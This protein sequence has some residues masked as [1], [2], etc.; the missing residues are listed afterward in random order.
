[1][2]CRANHWVRGTL[3]VMLTAGQR[4]G[5]A[6]EAC[7]ALAA[8]KE[9]E[10]AAAW[11]ADE[12]AEAR[13]SE[14]SFACPASSKNREEAAGAQEQAD[15]EAALR[16]ELAKVAA[17]QKGAVV[18]ACPAACDQALAAKNEE[19]AAGAWRADEAAKAVNFLDAP[20]KNREEAAGAQELADE[21]AALRDKLAEVAAA[22]K[23][24]MVMACP[25]ACESIEWWSETSVRCQTNNG[26][27]G[28]VRV[29]FTAG[30]RVGSVNEACDFEIP[31]PSIT[32]RVNRAG[33]GSAK[34][35]EQASNFGL[36]THTETIRIM[37]TACGSTEWWSQT[38]VQCRTSH[39][40]RGTHRMVMTTGERVGTV[41]E[42]WS[43]E[44]PSLSITTRLNR[45]GTG[46][47]S[48]TVHGTSFGLTT[49]TEAIRI[50]DTAC[51][52]TEWWSETTVR[53]RTWHGVRGTRRMMLTTGERVGTVTEAW[54][55]DTPML[56]ITTRVNQAGT[57][58]R[59]GPRPSTGC[60]S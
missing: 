58:A 15:R 38:S 8:K 46:S 54:S 34:V 44:I 30:E 49:Y 12:A 35:T 47:A 3:R 57:G 51:E 21:E 1:M 24:A 39:G 11:R 4:V 20:S 37:Y 25:A 27:R 6:N 55:I 19:E 33:S 45:A 10:A 42:A 40:E 2:R 60:E 48:V 50:M 28:T 29:V 16:E 9:E 18:M 59:L 5:R 26:V 41:T 36:T 23:R 53:C 14:S 22:W 56:S 13:M 17:A 32:T 43:I 7:E 52:S 31:C